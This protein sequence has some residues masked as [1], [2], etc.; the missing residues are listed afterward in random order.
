MALTPQQIAAKWAAGVTNGVENYRAGVAAVSVAPTESAI[1]A[2]PR[3]VEGVNRAVA[4]GR[5]E[6]GLRRVTLADWQRATLDKGA[7]RLATGARAAEGDFAQFMTEFMPFVEQVRA[8]LPPRGSL[9]EN[10]ARMVQNA[11]A[12]SEFRRRA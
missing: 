8:Q 3:Y 2:I 6:A 11:R 7:P 9:D 5:V 4:D 10:L 12:L 1:A